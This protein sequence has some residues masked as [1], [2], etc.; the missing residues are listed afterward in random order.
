[1]QVYF[2]S[3]KH[4]VEVRPILIRLV[5]SRYKYP[6][7]SIKIF[8]FYSPELQ[9]QIMQ[10]IKKV[11]VAKAQPLRDVSSFFVSYKII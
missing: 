6:Y 3:K 11:K 2:L 8:E 10:M 4:L 7:Y 9:Y 5:E 1:M